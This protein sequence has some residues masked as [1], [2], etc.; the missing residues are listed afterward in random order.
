MPSKLLVCI[1]ALTLLTPLARAN[2]PEIGRDGGTIVPLRSADV[3][4]AREE[5]IAEIEG[6]AMQGVVRCTYVLRNLSERSLHFEMSFV[7]DPQLQSPLDDERDYQS[8]RFRVAQEGR[9]LAVR[10]EPADSTEW[11]QYRNP[12][13]WSRPDSMPV[14]TVSLEPRDSTHL[15][16]DYRVQGTGGAD[17]GNWSNRFRYLTRA[18]KLWA[19]PIEKAEFTVR[20]DLPAILSQQLGSEW[21]RHLSCDIWPVPYHYSGGV[22]RWSYR[23]WEPE[24]D[25]ELEL[26]FI[27]SDPYELARGKPGRR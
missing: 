10:L 24:H 11:K 18:A 22:F 26:N 6:Q 2:G 3:Q 5:V 25:I 12:M 9:P 20:Y 8:P 27:E 16:I 23:D 13:A 15:S 1:V 21:T 7:T 4:L 19:G 14:F 17:G